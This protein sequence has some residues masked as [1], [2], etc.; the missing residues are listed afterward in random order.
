MLR[1]G[2]SLTEIGALLGHRHPDTTR[3]YSKVDLR[4]LRTLAQSWPGGVR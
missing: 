2:A 3:I 4:A 1:H